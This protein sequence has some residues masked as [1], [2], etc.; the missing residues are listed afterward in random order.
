MKMILNPEIGINWQGKKYMIKLY[1][2]VNEMLDKRHADIILA[3][4][5]SELREKLD[6]EV[7]FGILDVR[8]GILF[9]HVDNDPRLLIL[10][11]SE[12]LEFTE[13]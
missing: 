8:R 1:L 9:F 6:K 4:M 7:E 3:L 5:E 2:K 10:L 11:K 12:G 13:M